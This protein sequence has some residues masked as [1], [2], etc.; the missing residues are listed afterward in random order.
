V[1]Y[2]L[3]LCDPEDATYMHQTKAEAEATYAR[4]GRWWD[5]KEKRGVIKDGHQLQGPDKATTVRSKGG[6][7]V[8]TDGPFVEAKESVGGYALIEVPDID[9]AIA[10]ATEWIKF[11]PGSLVEVRP[12]APEG[13]RM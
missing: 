2:M 6:A 4:I 1:K 7:A 8:V 5:E 3:M 12:L 13:A 10:V 9:A 11:L